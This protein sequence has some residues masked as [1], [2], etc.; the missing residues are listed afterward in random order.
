[1]ALILTWVEVGL[2]CSAQKCNQLVIQRAPGVPRLEWETTGESSGSLQQPRCGAA[3]RKHKS[4][5]LSSLNWGHSQAGQE[6]RDLC[7]SAGQT[8]PSTPH[9][10]LHCQSPTLFILS[11][12]NKAFHP[13][14]L[15]HL[16][17]QKGL[18]EVQPF[19][20]PPWERPVLSF[21][22][23]L[24]PSSQTSAEEAIALMRFRVIYPRIET[25]AY[26][27]E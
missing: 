14:A 17:P 11:M 12:W 10:P 18:E 3:L 22:P 26:S 19:L 21:S 8:L 5:S 24:T 23:A 27:L 13:N 1:M 16:S 2:C 15:H 9:A 4:V 6:L 20:L 7:C 25:C